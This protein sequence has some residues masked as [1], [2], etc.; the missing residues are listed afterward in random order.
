[1]K[2][3]HELERSEVVNAQKQSMKVFIVLPAY[4]AAKILEQ[5]LKDIPHG[6]AHEIILVDDAIQDNT[7][8][9]ARKLGLKVFVHERNKGYG[10][11][12]K[13]CYKK[14]LELGADVVVMLY[15]DYQYDPTIIPQ[16][17]KPIFLGQ[18]DAVFGSRMM[19]GGALDGGMPCQY[20]IDRFGK[21]RFGYVFD[22][23]SFRIQGVQRQIP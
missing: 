5:T 2:Y 17:I 10:A 12:Q 15:P 21:C 22:R 9:V 20:F 11:N 1:M 7:V 19:K 23:I 18:A 13:T 3:L 4:N 6:L 16:L 8:E 14:A